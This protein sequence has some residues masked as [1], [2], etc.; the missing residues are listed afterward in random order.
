[1]AGVKAH[2]HLYKKDHYLLHH[3]ILKNELKIDH[4][5]EGKT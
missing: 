1:M 5:L 4:R 3:G 2:R